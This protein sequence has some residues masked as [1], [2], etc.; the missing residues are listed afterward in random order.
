M[1]ISVELRTALSKQRRFLILMSL[2]VIAFYALEVGVRNEAEY[3]GFGITLG[4][5]GRVVVGLWIIWGWSLWRYLQR[6][7]ELLSVLRRDVF[8]DVY[9]EDRRLAL[10]AAKREAR[11]RAKAGEIGEGHPNVKIM[12][13]DIEPSIAAIIRKEHTDSPPRP[14]PDFDRTKTGGRIYDTLG[15]SY[16]W[17]DNA[18]NHG[19]SS[20][21]FSMEWSPWGTRLHIALAAVHATLRLP[22]I[23]DHIVPLV[24]AV[25][26]VASPFIFG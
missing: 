19:A 7:Y 20:F 13:I 24:V 11:R 4:Q 8:E 3:S 15:G 1:E 5:P 6:V 2:A 26:A 18:G 17:H 12:D 22:A 10:K 21:N 14:E 25:A 9:A 16:E 23:A